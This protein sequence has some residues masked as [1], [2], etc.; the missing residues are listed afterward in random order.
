LLDA[1]GVRGA[2]MELDAAVQDPARV[3]RHRIEVAELA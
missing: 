1:Q 3:G 2:E